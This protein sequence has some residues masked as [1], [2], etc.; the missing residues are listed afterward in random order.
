M[1]DM[2]KTK[3][4]WTEL[5]TYHA[6]NRIEEHSHDFFHYIYVI[7]GLGDINISGKVYELKPKHMYLLS[8]GTVHSFYNKKEE[9]LLTIEIKFEVLD[10]AFLNETEHFPKILDVGATPVKRILANIRRECINKKVYFEDIVSANMQE[11]FAHLKRASLIQHDNNLDNSKEFYE[12]IEYINE[13][14]YKDITLQEL[15]DILC[16]EKTYFLKKFKK[17]MGVTPMLYTRNMRVERAKEL[18]KYSDMNITQ[19]S[20]AVGFFSIHHF[21]KHFSKSTGMSPSKFKK[22]NS[23]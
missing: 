6:K 5:C 18:L 8:P 10:E 15:A 1:M 22:E 21:S 20:E 2:I 23:I 9:N 16:L 3:V 19:I 4:Y 11:I 12:V 7:K 13:N 14:L 17:I